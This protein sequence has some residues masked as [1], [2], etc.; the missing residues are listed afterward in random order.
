MISAAE[1]SKTITSPKTNKRKTKH[2]KNKA[3]P[4]S[5]N[6]ERIDKISCIKC[7]LELKKE[8]DFLFTKGCFE[9]LLPF[10]KEVSSSNF[11]EPKKSTEG[12]Y[13]FG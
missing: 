5:G 4:P 12:E 7:A 9:A 6:D 8:V 3:I 2:N 13:L 11:L 1:V 10:E